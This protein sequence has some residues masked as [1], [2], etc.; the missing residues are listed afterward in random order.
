MRN[1]AKQKWLR[2]QYDSRATDEDEAVNREK[3][4]KGEW[5]Y[6]FRQERWREYGECYSPLL[7]AVTTLASI[8]SSSVVSCMIGHSG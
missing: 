7:S 1:M 4:E 5:R 6:G 3:R 2:Y 8:F